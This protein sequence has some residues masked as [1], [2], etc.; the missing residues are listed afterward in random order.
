MGEPVETIRLHLEALVAIREHDL[1]QAA[2]LL[3]Q[4]EDARPTASGTCGG[5]PFADFRDVDDVTASFFEVLATN[6][7]YFW[8]PID[9]VVSVEFHAP[10]RPR[11]LLWRKCEMT[12]RDGPDGEVCIPATYPETSAAQDN[13][14][15][16][17]RATDWS[18][19]DEEAPARG[20][21]QRIFLVDDEPIP[22]M[23][24]TTLEFGT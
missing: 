15:S 10:Q 11:D 5:K 3:R 6:G 14:L 9:R 22:I 2:V 7:S 12:V 16:L 20:R 4:A 21:G 24:L 18:G 23:Q 17:G 1:E 13:Q 8:I 19:G